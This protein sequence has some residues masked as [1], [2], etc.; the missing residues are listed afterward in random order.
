MSVPITVNEVVYQVPAGASD[1]NW[2]AKQIAFEQALAA[3][4]NAALAAG[5]TAQEFTVNS[6]ADTIP[7]DTAVVILAAGSS[8]DYVLSS[9]PPI[10]DGT[11]NGQRL[12]LYFT[13]A[14]AGSI[15]YTIDDVVRLNALTVQ[16]LIWDGSDWFDEL[17]Y[18]RAF[19][20]SGQ[21]F[22]PGTGPQLD[23]VKLEVGNLGASG[24]GGVNTVDVILTEDDLLVS[25]PSISSAGEVLDGTEVTII[26]RDPVSKLTLQ[27]NGTLNGSRL[28]LTTNTVDLKGGSNVRLRYFLADDFWYEV[29]RSILV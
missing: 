6:N 11:Y 12:T 25:T 3:A 7:S 16:S 26:C 8:A 29:A 20:I 1:T 13:Q 21:V 17:R 28:R 2:A 5:N 27:D 22:A 15:T 9:T 10:Q 23:P 14:G 19:E 4:V 18:G 24:S